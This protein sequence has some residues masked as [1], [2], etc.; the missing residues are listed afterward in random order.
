[1]D[2][3]GWLK[4][5][6]VSLIA[7]IAIGEVYA[8]GYNTSDF[9]AKCVWNDGA[10]TYDVYSSGADVY[11]AVLLEGNRALQDAFVYV[12]ETN[13]VFNTALG[14]EAGPIIVD[15]MDYAEQIRIYASVHGFNSVFIGGS[16]ELVNYISNTSSSPHGHAIIMVSQALPSSVYTGQLSDPILTWMMDGGAIYWMASEV[17]SY[18]HDGMGLHEVH[19]GQVLFLGSEC[20]NITTYDG[21]TED[22]GNG[23]RESLSLKTSSPLFGIHTSKT[24]SCLAA[25]YITDGISSITFIGRG[26]GTICVISGAANIDQYDDIGQLLASGIDHDTRIVEHV[27]GRVERGH[28]TGTI[29][30]NSDDQSLFIYIGG[31]YTMYGRLFTQ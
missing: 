2:S 20:Q 9:D 18:Y 4:V 31:I 17:G 11:D 10:L 21:H 7:V 14:S 24:N 12:D 27:D 8:Y 13:P 30:V 26:A 3:Y 16:E 5:L 29:S 19:D 28:V 6:A 1:M 25:G 15:S 22:V 23:F